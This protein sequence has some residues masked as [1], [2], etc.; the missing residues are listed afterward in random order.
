M[1]NRQNPAEW[2]STIASVTHIPLIAVCLY[3]IKFKYPQSQ[4]LKDMI[5][6]FVEFYGYTE[7][8]DFDG[9]RISA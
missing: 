2:V 3:M 9:K 8:I 5:D 1:D 7:I 4:E 6:G